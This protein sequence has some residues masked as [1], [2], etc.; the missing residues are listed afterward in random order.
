MNFVPSLLSI[1]LAWNCM[2]VSSAPAQTGPKSVEI[3][4]GVLF[5]EIPAGDN[6][7]KIWLYT[8]NPVP[9]KP[10]PAIFIAPA[11]SGSIFGMRLAEGDQAEHI[12]YAAAGYIVVA[13][14]LSGACH[15]RA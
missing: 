6:R 4:K 2:M 8:P 14:E 3:A 13:Y 15:G 11:G 10:V 9:T 12:P 1:A 7:P 5:S